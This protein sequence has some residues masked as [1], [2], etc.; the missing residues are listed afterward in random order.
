MVVIEIGDRPSTR[1]LGDD[2]RWKHLQIYNPPVLGSHSHPVT[3]TAP[4][5][6]RFRFG[7]EGNR[8]RGSATVGVGFT[9]C[10]LAV[11]EPG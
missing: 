11:V 8:E 3:P 1:R 4:I 10:L 5:S 6:V 9:F 7:N 2:R